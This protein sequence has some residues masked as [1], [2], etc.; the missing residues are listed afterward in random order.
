MPRA[1]LN[2]NIE[3]LDAFGLLLQTLNVTL[4][5][6][7]DETNFVIEDG[8]IFIKDYDDRGEL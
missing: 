4:K 3:P 5:D 1:T 8:E 7:I 6:N 2:F